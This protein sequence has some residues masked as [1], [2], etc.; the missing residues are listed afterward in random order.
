MASFAQ[1]NSVDSFCSHSARLRSRLTSAQP[2][3][4]ANRGEQAANLVAARPRRKRRHGQ[5]RNAEVEIRSSANRRVARRSGNAVSPFLRSV[6]LWRPCRRPT[7]FVVELAFSSR[8]N[9]VAKQLPTVYA[10]AADQKVKGPDVRSRRAREARGLRRR[11]SLRRASHRK[12]WRRRDDLGDPATVCFRLG[13]YSECHKAIG[14]NACKDS[15]ASPTNLRTTLRFAM[16][17]GAA[18]MGTEES[19]NRV[20]QTL[21][22]PN[23]VWERGMGERFLRAEFR[24]PFAACGRSGFPFR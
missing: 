3:L 16:G 9:D 7:A 13:C 15:P 4:E 22:F 1:F 12:P 23:R 8:D 24:F 10:G 20:S 11:Q 2:L 19:G 14:A 18:A 21:P 6:R 17:Y 5:S